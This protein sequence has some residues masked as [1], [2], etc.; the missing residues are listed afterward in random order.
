L[1]AEISSVHLIFCYVQV[2]IQ[3]VKHNLVLFQISSIKLKIW[4]PPIVSGAHEA[5]N[6]F[7]FTFILLNFSLGC[8]VGKNKLQVMIVSRMKLITGLLTL[9][10]NLDRRKGL[11][12]VRS[13]VYR[14]YW[15]SITDE[16]S[17]PEIWKQK[18][19]IR[20]SIQW[21]QNMFKVSF[22]DVIK[23]TH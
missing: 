18:R 3:Q 23:S 17:F 11:F 19:L 12:F 21:D 13:F 22:R 8:K 20:K 5:C 1:C 9:M 2:I 6:Q 4:T 7:F 14:K 10:H 15:Y 16:K